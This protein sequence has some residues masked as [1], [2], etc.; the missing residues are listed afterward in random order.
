MSDVNISSQFLSIFQILYEG[1]L[2]CIDFLDSIFISSNVSLLDICIAV[3]LIGTFLP[4]LIGLA[5]SG[6]HSS[7]HYASSQK[8]KAESR[9]E[10]E[11]RKAEWRKVFNSYRRRG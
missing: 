11:R 7:T 8:R 10:H 4:M 9:A 6:Y 3:V 2:Y 5:S 1:V